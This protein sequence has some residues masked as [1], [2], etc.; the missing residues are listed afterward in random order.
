MSAAPAPVDEGIS[1]EDR[2]K[3][4]SARSRDA[5]MTWFSLPGLLLFLGMTLLGLR[6]VDFDG[7]ARSHPH[8]AATRLRH[9]PCAT[10]RRGGGHGSPTCR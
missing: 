8:R 2:L 9:Q 4:I 1:T 3:R 5:R 7:M 6:D 10:A